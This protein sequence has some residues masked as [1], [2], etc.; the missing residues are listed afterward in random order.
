MLCL[1]IAFSLQYSSH[2]IL[3]YFQFVNVYSYKQLLDFKNMLC[4]FSQ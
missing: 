3:S 1:W 4:V 2:V